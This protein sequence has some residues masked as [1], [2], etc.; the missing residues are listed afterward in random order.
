MTSSRPVGRS[1]ART[2]PCASVVAQLLQRSARLTPLVSRARWRG[3]RAARAHQQAASTRPRRRKL[4]L[5]GREPGACRI[6]S[7]PAGPAS[8]D[9][10]EVL[11]AGSGVVAATPS[12]IEPVIRPRARSGAMTSS[13]RGPRA[14]GPGSAGRAQSAMR[15]SGDRAAG[16]HAAGLRGTGPQRGAELASRCPLRQGAVVS[17]GA[18]EVEDARDVVERRAG[19]PARRR[20]EQMEGDGS[21]RPRRAGDQPAPCAGRNG[22]S[23]VRRRPRTGA[24]PWA[25]RDSPRSR[26]I[27]PRGLGQSRARAA[28]SE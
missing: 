4:A 17:G 24:G 20:A 18:D 10:A 27:A 3:P 13:R 16:L 21:P 23:P 8:A 12:A 19:P 11:R 26:T 22:T 28:G 1:R 7:E 25:A 5:A 9:E 14:S 2:A 6:A 15:I